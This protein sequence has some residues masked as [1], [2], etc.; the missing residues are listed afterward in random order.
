MKRILCFGDSNTWGNMP[1]LGTRYPKDVRW[2]GI[3]AKELGE[4]YEI[5]EDGLNGRTTVYDDYFVD[6]R[7]G[8][9]GLGYSL[10]ANAPIDLVILSLG[11]NDL[12]YTDAIGTYKGVEE[13]LHFMTAAEVVCKYPTSGG[14]IF[15]DGLKV[16]VVSPI[17]LHKDIAVKRPES[18][19][20]DKYEEST[21]FAPYFCAVAERRGAYFLDAAMYA[22]PSEKDCIHMDVESHVSLGHGIAE[23]VRSIFA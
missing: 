10:C 4:E 2:T 13:L 6:Y 16:L 12:K 22:V 9:K 5:I 23:K 21:R 7:N 19:V 18:A 3:L 15:P 14:M 8:K 1:G 11:T 17:A 20:A